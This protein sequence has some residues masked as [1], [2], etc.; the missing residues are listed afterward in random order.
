A[1]LE[2]ESLAGL[3][4]A[5]VV[6]G[7]CDVLRAE[8]R[9]YAARLAADGVP[10]DEVCLAGQPHGFLNLGFPAAERAYDHVGRWLR[11]ILDGAA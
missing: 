1:P 7:G 2:A 8:G 6:R 4:P 9:A 3:P 11:P 5:L 10:V